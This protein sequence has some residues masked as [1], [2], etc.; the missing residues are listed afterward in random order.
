MRLR[1]A[2]VCGGKFA[3]NLQN[4]KLGLSR[5]ESDGE[6]EGAALRER[7][8]PPCEDYL[9]IMAYIYR[10]SPLRINSALRVTS[11]VRKFSLSA[12]K[13]YRANDQC[14]RFLTCSSPRIVGGRAPPLHDRPDNR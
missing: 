3:R 11:A 10:L 4:G 7:I 9:I 6:K 2:T 8:F 5:L 1:H 12:V 14:V 13:I